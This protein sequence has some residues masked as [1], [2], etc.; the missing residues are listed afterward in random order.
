MNCP[1]VVSTKPAVNVKGFHS[2]GTKCTADV[3]ASTDPKKNNDCMP[4]KVGS[5][6]NVVSQ[7]CDA[8]CTTA[9]VFG[10]HMFPDSGACVAD[11]A[12]PN[13]ACTTAVT[14]QSVG[15]NMECLADC[16]NTDSTKPAKVNTPG[17]HDV[18]KTCTADVAAS[19][20]AKKNNDC[21][22]VTAGSSVNATTQ[23]CETACVAAAKGSH[24]FN[25]QCVED[26]AKPNP[27]CTD[28]TDG[29]S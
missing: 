19:T 25:G 18:G 11:T 29:S 10:S 5:T 9:A 12:K 26:T 22:P 27:A 15:L 1:D 20:D 13:A 6:V 4:V 2:D 16:P 21:M 24:K 23:K 7:A 3:A 8:D 14:G 17:Y 28:A